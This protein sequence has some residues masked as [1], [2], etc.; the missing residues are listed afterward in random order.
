VAAPATPIAHL[1]F[2]EAALRTLRASLGCRDL[3]DVEFAMFVE[4]CKRRRLDPFCR[5]MYAVKRRSRRDGSARVT[6]QTG[7]DG[8]RVIAERSGRYEGQVGPF[9]CGKDGA[10]KDVWLTTEPPVAAKVGVFKRGFRETLW[11]TA[12]YAAYVQTT[13]YGPTEIWAKMADNQLA[14]CAEALGLRKAVP[15]DLGGLYLQEEMD[16]A[17]SVEAAVVVDRDMNPD[18]RSKGVPANPTPPPAPSPPLLNAVDAVKETYAQAW[19][20]VKTH[21]ELDRLCFQ[22]AKAL[23]M[24]TPPEGKRWFEEMLAQTSAALG[25]RPAKGGAR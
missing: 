5:Q 3:D 21:A 9:W 7:I 11:G 24:D 23:G 16:Q 6:H 4:D 25:P 20:K 12:R 1:D 10:W 13:D 19:A 22:V 14:K 2:S 8:F 18:N 15:E 17:D